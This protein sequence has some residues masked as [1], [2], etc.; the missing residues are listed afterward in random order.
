[1]AVR[2]RKSFLGN[3]ILVSAKLAGGVRSV[4]KEEI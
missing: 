3:I 1:M 2:V 4:L